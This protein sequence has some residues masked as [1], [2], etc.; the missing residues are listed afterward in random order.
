MSY[1]L[2]FL[3]VCHILSETA[4]WPLVRLFPA[5]IVPRSSIDR[6][7]SI[8]QNRVTIESL[9]MLE[10]LRQ[11]KH[12]I[13]GSIPWS[14]FISIFLLSDFMKGTK[15]RNHGSKWIPLMHLSVKRMKLGQPNC[16]WPVK[17]VKR[18]IT[19]GHIMNNI[20]NMQHI[21]EFPRWPPLSK[22]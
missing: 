14:W 8:S 16:S 19:F 17:P 11:T 18:C 20:V 9:T 21:V 7:R 22:S 15:K 2:P 4:V 6:R 10:G 3:V 12:M 13:T 5:W 1:F